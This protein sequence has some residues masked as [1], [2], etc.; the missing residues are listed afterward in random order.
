[1]I[2]AEV[3]TVTNPHIGVMLA[4]LVLWGPLC[5][6]TNAQKASMPL[7]SIKQQVLSLNFMNNGQH[8]RAT[9]GQQIEITLGTVGPAQYGVPLVSS[10]AVRLESTALNWPPNPGGPTFVY[11]FEAVAA[12]EAQVIIPI[13]HS[14][15][16]D[17]AQRNTFVTMIRVGPAHGK[18]RAFGKPD[19]ANTAT[20]TKAWTNLLNDTEQ[21]FVPSLPMLT[22][23]E[24]G[25][26]VGNPGPPDEDLTLTLLNPEGEVLAVI[27][28]TV[29]AEDCGQV[30]FLFPKGGAQV[31][32]GLVYSIRL[33]GGSLYGWKYV[34]GGYKNGEALFNGK[35]LLQGGH[36]SFLFR[37]FGAN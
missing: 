5:A 2:L 17:Y 3:E 28:K 31:S 13:L 21:T 7:A 30:R 32:P 19:Q 34:V 10:T 33:K 35:P 20:W 9:V 22:S 11:I 25:L 15:D 16:P 6:D 37:T 29:P 26:V 8:A 1:M 12:G 18:P 14:P 36:S 24:V 4:A 27:S 23:V